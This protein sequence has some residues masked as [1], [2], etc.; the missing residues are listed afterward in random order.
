MGMQSHCGSSEDVL[1][2]QFPRAAVKYMPGHGHAHAPHTSRV[3]T[4]GM[5]A[6]PPCSLPGL[7]DKEARTAR[8]FGDPL[9]VVTLRVLPSP[10]TKTWD[11]PAC[12]VRTCSGDGSHCGA[13]SHRGVWGPDQGSHWLHRKTTGT[14]WANMLDTSAILPAWV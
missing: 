4:R 10:A 6:A 11:K 5:P 1:P 2:P 12:S 9:G 8:R 13:R 7:A 3:L 14:A